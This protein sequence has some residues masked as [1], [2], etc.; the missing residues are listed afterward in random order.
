MFSPSRSIYTRALSVQVSALR[1]LYVISADV[2][3]TQNSHVFVK[4]LLQPDVSPDL[5]QVLKNLWAQSK[6]D[7]G[8]IRNVKPVVITPK[9]SFRPHRQQYRLKPPGLQ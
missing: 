3:Q 9:S 1:T 5:L 4:T 8:L 2:E 6:H 7:L